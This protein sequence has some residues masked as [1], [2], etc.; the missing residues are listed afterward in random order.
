[1][2]QTFFN[3]Y[4]VCIRY[5]PR[6][7]PPTG[8]G[9]VT[10]PNPFPPIHHDITEHVVPT[11]RHGARRPGFRRTPVNRPS[12]TNVP[13]AAG[14]PASWLPCLGNFHCKVT[15]RPPRCKGFQEI[16]LFSHR[17]KKSISRT[18]PCLR[19]LT[20]NFPGS[21]NIPDTQPWEG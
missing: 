6:P 15:R 1:M 14:T 16:F 3:N 10:L 2:L 5:I 19:W 9:S 12:F 20:T 7:C 11:R 4:V 21:E 18:F 8:T 17:T 13:Q